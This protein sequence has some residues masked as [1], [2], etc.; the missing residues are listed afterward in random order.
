MASE[1]TETEAE[2]SCDTSDYSS[3]KLSAHIIH[4]LLSKKNNMTLNK[5]HKCAV[6]YYRDYPDGSK[7]VRS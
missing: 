7:K 3:K 2:L 6:W 4:F 1:E 5:Q